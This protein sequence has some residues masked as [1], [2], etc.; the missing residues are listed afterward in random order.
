MGWIVVFLIWMGVLGERGHKLRA[1]KK[2]EQLEAK[3]QRQAARD[4]LRRARRDVRRDMLEW[5]DDRARRARKKFSMTSPPFN[6]RW[7]WDVQITV[8]NADELSRDR[9]IKFENFGDAGHVVKLTADLFKDGKSLCPMVVEDISI[10]P[11]S[12]YTPNLLKDLKLLDQLEPDNPDHT[13]KLI[14]LLNFE[15]QCIYPLKRPNLRRPIMLT[16]FAAQ[17][18]NFRESERLN[19]P[20]QSHLTLRNARATH[21]VALVASTAMTVDMLANGSGPEFLREG[22]WVSIA[23]SASGN[24][25]MTAFTLLLPAL[26]VRTIGPSP[27][28]W[29]YRIVTWCFAAAASIIVA[30]QLVRAAG[31]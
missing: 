9:L 4:E 21:I 27:A 31:F 8:P 14:R 1:E 22:N 12:S 15:P 11:K 29:T 23:A 5:D 17:F 30:N 13:S 10:P 28:V 18:L 2:R 7:K 19:V 25:C 16:T 3:W 26:A 20:K 6:R 24:I